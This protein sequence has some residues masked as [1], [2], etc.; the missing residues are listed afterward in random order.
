M[1]NLIRVSA[2]QAATEI[3][4]QRLKPSALVAAYLERIDAR[5]PQVGAFD[6]VARDTAMALAKQFDQQAPSGLLFGIPIGVKNLIDTKDMV[7]TYGSPIYQ[8]HRPAVDAACVVQSK[9][10]GA[11]VLGKT[12]TTEFAVFNP[13]KTANPHNLDH[14]PGGSSSGS[15]A[16]V[17]D[18]MLPLAFGTQTAASIYRPASFCGVVGYKPSFGTIVRA[19]AKPLADSLDTIGTLANSVQDAALFAAA[20]GAR[21]DLVLKSGVTK[22]TPRIGVCRTYEWA[23]AQPE[24]QQTLEACAHQLSGSGAKVVK[25]ELPK[26]FQG[27]VAAQIDIMT[28][29]SAMA[30]S[31][32][33]EYSR[34]M[35]STKLIE[36]IEQG[37]RVTDARLLEAYAIVDQCRRLLNDIYKDFDALLAPAARGEAP[38]GLAA[39]GDPIFSRMWTALGNPGVVLPWGKGPNGLPVGVLL[40]GRYQADY[41]LLEVA[42]WAEQQRGD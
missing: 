17:A 27:L 33:Y 38:E 30:L 16:A 28:K 26:P 29:E 6:H 21:H 14:T 40:A 5:E 11:I 9:K 23:F 12:V 42:R 3:A 10:Q 35:L 20:A 34:S 32:E 41:A 39:T 8:N 4:Q 7:T 31:A 19:G 37:L 25:F 15:A 24:T 13:G 36:V 18:R 22:S 2:T 1:S